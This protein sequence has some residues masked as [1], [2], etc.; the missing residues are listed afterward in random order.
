M[1]KVHMNAPAPSAFFGREKEEQSLH[2]HP[3]PDHS[4]RSKQGGEGVFCKA[5]AFEAAEGQ[6][7]VLRLLAPTQFTIY[8]LILLPARAQGL[9]KLSCPLL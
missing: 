7:S 6:S 1:G 3:S 5:C 8:K 2:V 9:L 4:R